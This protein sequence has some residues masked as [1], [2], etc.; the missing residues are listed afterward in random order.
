MGKRSQERMPGHS[1]Q[2]EQ[3]RRSR[4]KEGPKAKESQILRPKQRLL[5]PRHRHAEQIPLTEHPAT[6]ELFI[7]RPD[8]QTTARQDPNSQQALLIGNRR[9]QGKG[10][11]VI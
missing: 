4:A 2:E 6:P 10:L 8:N 9:I 5:K 7:N 3:G 1:E 11:E